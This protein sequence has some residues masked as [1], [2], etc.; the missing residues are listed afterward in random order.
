MS[1]GISQNTMGYCKLVAGC[2]GGVGLAV[3]Y[4]TGAIG[5]AL[6]AIGAIG[7]LL[8]I[9][10]S[11]NASHSSSRNASHKQIA[12]AQA[13][14]LLMTPGL[15]DYFRN[16]IIETVASI[17]ANERVQFINLA[18]RL[19]HPGMLNPDLQIVIIIHALA[20]MPADERAQAV[21]LALNCNA[22]ALWNE[23]RDA[24]LFT[25]QHAGNERAGRMQRVRDQIPQDLANGLE[26]R[27]IVRRILVL[28][29][30]PLNQPIPPLRARMA[31]LAAEGHNA[32]DVHHGSRDAKTREAI[33]LL[34]KQQGPLETNTIK[35]AVG[36]FIQYLNDNK[37]NAEIRAKA[38]QALNGPD[39]TWPPLLHNHALHAID[40][41][42]LRISGEELIAR[43]WIF[44][45]E[46]KSE[47]ERENCRFGIMKALSD[48]IE[49]GG[50]VCPPG[51]TQRQVISVLQ[52][53]LEGVNVDDV[54]V[55]RAKT[56]NEH[57][58]AFLSGQMTTTDRAQLIQAAGE[59]LNQNPD[60]NRDAFMAA[61]NTYANNSL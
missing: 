35:E 31:E 30:T 52:G 7:C 19:M 27:D 2:V 43:L 4:Q 41:G 17:P 58:A 61:I 13:S 28:L 22:E 33:E 56:L 34:K 51:Q 23:D 3:A 53:R 44:A 60:V 38:Q 39:E 14:G 36:N 46:Q 12:A 47:T 9:S 25:I 54:E 24:I 6:T 1:T 10:S 20:A 15:D 21:A 42:R 37:G 16:R 40:G 57:T 11:R 29:E 59:Y 49:Y 50:R 5:P 18:A 45:N 32:I 26:N 48:S 55:V 8:A